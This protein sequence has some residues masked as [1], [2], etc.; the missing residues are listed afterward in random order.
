MK[1]EMFKKTGDELQGY[2]HFKKRGGAPRIKK[3]KG[4]KYSRKVKHKNKGDSD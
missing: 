1:K 4:S 2:F 3:G